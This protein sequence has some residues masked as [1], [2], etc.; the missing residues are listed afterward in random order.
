[1]D[2]TRWSML[3]VAREDEAHW[4][5]NRSPVDSPHKGQW[6]G[7][8]MFSLI[9]PWTNVWANN[10]DTGDLRFHHAHYDVTVMNK[11]NVFWSCYNLVKHLLWVPHILLWWVTFEMSIFSISV[12]INDIITKSTIL[13]QTTLNQAVLLQIVE[14][15][16]YWMSIQDWASRFSL[17]MLSWNTISPDLDH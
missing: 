12:E 2:D 3:V 9:C 7:A 14:M 10:R 1:M 15:K 13:L 5:G 4:T 16:M 17:K 11:V 6:C 8:L